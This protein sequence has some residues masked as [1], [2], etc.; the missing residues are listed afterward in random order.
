MLRAILP[1]RLSA[2]LTIVHL[3]RAT[4]LV[5]SSN[6]LFS[7]LIKPRQYRRL[8]AVVRALSTWVLHNTKAPRL[9]SSAF[10]AGHP[11]KTSERRQR[12]NRCVRGPHARGGAAGKAGAL[13]SLRTSGS[14]TSQAAA[15]ELSTLATYIHVLAEVGTVKQAGSHERGV[16]EDVRLLHLLDP[17]R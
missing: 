7:L 4:K 14:C 13:L 12:E 10:V 15:G 1:R 5:P 9:C 2:V 3:Q 8:A 11:L 17:L 16:V 6:A